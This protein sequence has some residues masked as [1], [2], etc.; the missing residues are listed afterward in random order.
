M[1]IRK[2]Q[3][4]TEE[5]LASES[6]Q[7]ADGPVLRKIAL[8]AVV[9]NPYAGRF[10]QQLNLLVDPSSGLGKEFGRRIVALLAGERAQSVGKACIVGVEGEYEQRERRWNQRYRRVQAIALRRDEDAGEKRPAAQPARHFER[11]ALQAHQQEQDQR[12]AGR[13]HRD[14]GRHARAVV[15]RY[16]RRQVVR[17]EG[18]RH[19]QEDRN[20]QAQ[21][22]KSAASGD[23]PAP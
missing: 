17:R 7:A 21:R 15:E 9:E 5:I 6:G 23:R 22:Q 8:A 19:A 18:A 2:W 16:A 12:R 3:T 11:H 13:A 1:N 4:F 20:P 14:A 10:S